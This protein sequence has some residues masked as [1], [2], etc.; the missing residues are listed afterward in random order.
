MGLMESGARE[1]VLQIIHATEL[2][3]AFPVFDL[4]AYAARQNQTNI[5]PGSP[6]QRHDVLEEPLQGNDVRVVAGTE[7]QEVARC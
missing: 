7:E 4:A 5:R 1:G 6:D 3:N 2:E